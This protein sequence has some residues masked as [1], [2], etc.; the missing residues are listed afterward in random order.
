MTLDAHFQ[1]EEVLGE[2][3]MGVVY[4]ARHRAS[5]HP[6]AIK[7]LRQA[8]TAKRVQQ[9][10]REIR[11]I[12][13]MHHPHV[14]RVYDRGISEGGALPAGSP[15]VVMQ[16]ARP[17]RA[18]LPWT[19]AR[20]LL[21][22]VLSALAHAHSRGVLH[23]DV[24]PSNILVDA[25]G[26]ARLADFGIARLAE[27]SGGGARGT[28]TYMPPEQMA[29]TEGLGPW[30]DLY[31]LGITAWALL[32]ARTPFPALDARGLGRL[33]AGFVLPDPPGASPAV[34][35][36]LRRLAEPMAEQRFAHAA[37]ALA[38]MPALASGVA[39]VRVA[40]MD[41]ATD[42][43]D[44]SATLDTRA[45]LGGASALPASDLAELAKAEAPREWRGEVEDRRVPRGMGLG[46]FGLRHLPMVGR[47]TERDALWSMLGAVRGDA[48]AAVC[49]LVG[50]MGVGKRRLARWLVEAA[51]EAGADGI[52]L[53]PGHP[54]DLV[55][56]QGRGERFAVRF[57]AEAA[58]LADTLVDPGARAVERVKSARAVVSARGSQRPVVLW[59]QGHAQ[60][61]MA[62]ALVEELARTPG[63]RPVLVVVTLDEQE[64]AA[65]PSLLSTG[66]RRLDIGPLDTRAHGLLVRDALGLSGPL[67]HAVERQTRG[68]PAFAVELVGDWVARG[69]L[70]PGDDGFVLAVDEVPRLPDGLR[71]VWQQRLAPLEGQWPVLAY[72]AMLGDE[73]DLARWSAATGV[74]VSALT[75][76]L[77]Q[78]GLARP[79]D[80]GLTWAHPL[81]PEV[82]RDEA[83]A[84]GKLPVV[85][86]ACAAVVDRPE[87][88]GELLLEAGLAEQA[89]ESLIAGVRERTAAGDVR[90]AFAVAES[91]VRALDAVGAAP[92][93]PERLLAL[94]A[95]AT[96]QRTSGQLDEALAS[97]QAVLAA[98]GVDTLERAM[99]WAEVAACHQRAGRFPEAIA[100]HE[101]AVELASAGNH[102]TFELQARTGL[103][104]A[105][106]IH[107]GAGGAAAYI[108][109]L[110][111]AA[112]AQGAGSY[113]A[114]ADYF[115]SYACTEVD[116]RLR[117]LRQASA[118][119]RGHPLF[120]AAVL[121]A[122]GGALGD[123]GRHEE[124]WSALET[125]AELLDAG[126]S[127]AAV[128]VRL[129]MV[130]ALLTC[131]R[132]ED[133]LQRLPAVRAEFESQKREAMVGAVWTLS[134]WGRAAL[135][136]WEA[137]EVEMERGTAL[138]RSTGLVTR[139]L[140]R[141]YSSVHELAK[142]AGRAN[143][144]ARAS[145]EAAAMWQ[146]V[147]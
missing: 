123:A 110:R 96:W 77:W 54:E 21:A 134:A 90:E 107:R 40:P 16:R 118:V 11:L 15:Y 125:A 45:V 85:C 128:V 127:S 38:A 44:L 12:S 73:V 136:E 74:E 48:R 34:G 91:L 135:G 137:C 115:Q 83:R 50:P 17:C 46:L 55:G 49:A 109:A 64:L 3:G 111:E 10:D 84:R 120:G 103:A 139:D 37:D 70:V 102:A 32:A 129:N 147:S 26:R 69:I 132:P 71:G 140:A 19:E 4:A 24:K 81:V 30:T 35:A 101:R 53:R 51:G 63:S 57:G 88:R 52:V 106:I 133:A 89:L 39:D 126:G 72:A 9:L 108:D 93:A 100:A 27:D 138:L 67:A 58:G 130:V 76:A 23:L 33:K 42:T 92:D 142:A 113:A 20:P 124:A 104:E 2:G 116:E 87:T 97:A 105:V 86:L 29:G 28:P 145:A 143:L 66:M 22:G 36:W 122:L 68:N 80:R 62:R 75:D 141:A 60:G 99:A 6:V 131:D 117:L 114:I 25:H 59:A 13:A 65:D 112:T 7:C 82:L 41:D 121:N 61:G 146:R 79:T 56:W 47:E 43:V 144:A 98:D 14:L 95:R 119:L 8:P 78:H 5:G 94:R 31:A 18:P 1:L